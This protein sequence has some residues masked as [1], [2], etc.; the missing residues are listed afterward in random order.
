ML[1]SEKEERLN[2]NKNWAWKVWRGWRFGGRFAMPAGTLLGLTR[3]TWQENSRT[4]D[5][6]TIYRYVEGV[7]CPSLQGMHKSVL[8]LLYVLYSARL[9]RVDAGGEQQSG[10]VLGTCTHYMHTLYNER[11]ATQQADLHH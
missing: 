6:T 5:S 10:V 3:W 11:Q 8:L 4:P 9:R 7:L 1:Q 2:G